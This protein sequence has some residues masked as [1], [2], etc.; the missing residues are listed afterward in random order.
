VKVRAVVDG[1]AATLHATSPVK[2]ITILR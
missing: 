2:R 1:T